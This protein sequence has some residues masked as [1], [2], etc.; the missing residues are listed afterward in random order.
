MKEFGP[1]KNKT[2]PASSFSP[3]RL[4]IESRDARLSAGWRPHSACTAWPLAGPLRRI[5]AT[6]EGKPPLDKAK[7]VSVDIMIYHSGC[8]SAI[9]FRRRIDFFS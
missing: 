1:G 3:F 5:T 9:P 6:P 2:R 4:R 7:I 8:E